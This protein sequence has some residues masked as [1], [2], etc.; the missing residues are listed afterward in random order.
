MNPVEV[1]ENVS[2]QEILGDTLSSR[3]MARRSALPQSSP[4]KTATVKEPEPEATTTVLAFGLVLVYGSWNSLLPDQIHPALKHWMTAIASQQDWR[5]SNGN[6]NNNNTSSS[7]SSS[8]AQQSSG[9]TPF[10]ASVCVDQSEESMQFFVGEN[11]DTNDKRRHGFSDKPRRLPIPPHQLPVLAVVAQRMLMEGTVVRDDDVD[12]ASNERLVYLYVRSVSSADL[13]HAIQASHNNYSVHGYLNTSDFVRTILRPIQGVVESAEL[14]MI[15]NNNNGVDES[16]LGNRLFADACL[17]NTPETTA[18]RQSALRIFVAG[19]R[20]SVGKSTI[21]LGLLGSLMA[22]GIATPATLAYIK[23]AT[24][25]ESTQLIQ[26]YCDKQGI[27]CVPV[28][29]LVYYRGFTR[30]FLANE[31]PST[32]ELLQQCAEAVDRVA[33]GKTVVVIDGVGFPAVGSICGTSNAAVARACGYQLINDDTVE[34]NN[35]GR[36]SPLGVILVGGSGVGQAVDAFNLNASYF[37]HQA[38]LPVLGGIFNKLSETGYYSLESCKAQLTAYFATSDEQICR[39][40]QA[41]GFLPQFP[42][43]TGP[44][45]MDHVD[46]YIQLFGNLVDVASIIRLAQRTKDRGIVE[47]SLSPFNG[48]DVATL[49]QGT[50]RDNVSV[51]RRLIRKSRQEV[52]AMAI[53]AGAPISA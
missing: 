34:N 40:R 30:A 7:S 24:Q 50:K 22:M 52:E 20:S 12:D 26:L 3:W 16:G 28:G 38:G 25:N 23:P 1:L 13:I 35:I 11:D 39:E 36:R 48:H 6:N 2:L 15:S 17:R 29:P 46:E 31:T 53:G 37:E 32:D 47:P 33:R 51:D 43:I 45:A 27:Q 4:E 21:C 49:S 44:Y 14:E 8:P 10:V 41:F 19:D 42:R 9:V 18:T 5:I